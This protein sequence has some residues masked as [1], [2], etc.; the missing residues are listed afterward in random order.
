M[1][2]LA[3]PCMMDFGQSHFVQGISRE[4]QLST[5]SVNFGPEALMGSWKV[6]CLVSGGPC[7]DDLRDC[8][9]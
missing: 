1:P 7:L 4:A 8:L 9:D 2:A 5:V 6:A 3:S